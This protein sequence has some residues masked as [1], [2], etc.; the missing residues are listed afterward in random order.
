MNPLI[1]SDS[2]VSFIEPLNKTPPCRAFSERAEV[3]CGR[4]FSSDPFGAPQG[5]GVKLATRARFRTAARVRAG[6]E[7]EPA[8]QSLRPGDV[9]RRFGDA[10]TAMS[11]GSLGDGPSE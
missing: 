8:D 9:V 2:Y 4:S 3:L 10:E 7:G 11:G 6:G 1:Q 5:L